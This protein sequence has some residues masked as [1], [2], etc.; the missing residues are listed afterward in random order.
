MSDL[1][2]RVEDLRML[3]KGWNGSNSNPLTES[4]IQSAISV[5]KDLVIRFPE[6]DASYIQIT[7]AVGNEIHFEF[8]LNGAI[9]FIVANSVK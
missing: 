1:I 8:K 7:P 4:V 3:K 6:I 5:A 9:Y 2:K